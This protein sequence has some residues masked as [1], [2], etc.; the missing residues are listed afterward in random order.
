M[1][2]GKVSGARHLQA[3]G[4]KLLERAAVHFAHNQQMVCTRHDAPGSFSQDGESTTWGNKHSARV[5]EPIQAN[6]G[7][8]VMFCRVVSCHVA[9]GPVVSCRS[10]HIVDESYDMC[11][12]K[13]Y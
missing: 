11:L 1:S 2:C 8:H 9:F 5:F 7:C 6:G 4:D 12:D 3:A 13:A 10:C